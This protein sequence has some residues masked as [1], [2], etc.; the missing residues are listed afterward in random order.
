MVVPTSPTVFPVLWKDSATLYDI[1]VRD[2]RRS[3]G[4]GQLLL[5]AATQSA[6]D[7]GARSIM[8][9]T[10]NVNVPACRFYAARGAELAVIDRYAYAED[11]SHPDTADEVLLVWR[12][13]L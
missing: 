5:A 2:D 1:R 7:Q 12:L 9:E 4:I 13:G 11:S 8:I 6:R 10:Q 3:E